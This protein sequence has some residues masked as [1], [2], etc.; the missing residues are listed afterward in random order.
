[1]FENVSRRNFLQVSAAGVALLGLAG[2]NGSNDSAG[3]GEGGSGSIKVGIMG[4]HTGEN[5]SYGL[6]CPHGAPLYL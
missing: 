6:A 2:C 3:G 1:M 4:P 5:S